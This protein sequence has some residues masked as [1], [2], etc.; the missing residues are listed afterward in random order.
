MVS[1]QMTLLQT[2]YARY[3]IIFNHKSTKYVLNRDWANNADEYD[4]KQFLRSGD[5]STLNLYYVQSVQAD[6]DRSIGKCTMPAPGVSPGEDQFV[7][8]GCVVLVQTIPGGDR[9]GVNL[10]MTTIHEAGHW[11][12][13]Q[14]TFFTGCEKSDSY[15]MDTKPE[16]YPSVGCPSGRNTCPDPNDPRPDPVHNYMDWSDDHC[17]TEFSPGQM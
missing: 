3:N 4:M 16:A 9:A 10:G 5:Y 17:M 14:H 7:M 12:G 11:F 1:Q 13:L 6:N 15:I 8:D 2:T